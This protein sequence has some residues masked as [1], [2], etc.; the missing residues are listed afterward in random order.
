MKITKT[1]NWSRRDFSYDATCEHCGHIERSGS[2]YDDDNY[3]NNVIPKVNCKKCGES[4]NSKST[5]AP[6]TVVVPRYDPNIVM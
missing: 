2:G 3:Y 4:S 5:D 1:Y 6:K